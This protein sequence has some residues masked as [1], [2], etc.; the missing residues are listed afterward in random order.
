[1][2]M[3]HSIEIVFTD[4]HRSYRESL[5]PRLK[6]EGIETIGEANNGRELLKVL[7]TKMPDILLLDLYMK[8]MHGIDAFQIIKKKYPRLKIII[9]SGYGD[10]TLQNKFK[11]MGANSYLVKD[12][13]METIVDTIK[14]VHKSSSYNNVKGNL[15]SSFTKRE[16]EVT[17]LIIA[18]MTSKQIAANLKVSPRTVENV[19][20]RL[21]EKTKTKNS[22]EFSA[23]CA[24]EGLNFLG[25]WLSD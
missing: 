17:P 25:T 14:K 6:M 20:T 12:M 5:I 1:M 4:D 9:L 13:P 10:T 3:S 23:H 21:Y 7:E 2:A 16:I 24:L 8:E 19:R 22:S 11:K 18:G 15:K